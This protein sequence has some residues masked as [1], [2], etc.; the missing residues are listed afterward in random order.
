MNNH[1]KIDFH[2]QMKMLLLR[3]SY[4]V[5]DKSYFRRIASFKLYYSVLIQQ[6]TNWRCFPYLSKK[7]GHISLCRLL[8][9]LPQVLSASCNA[10]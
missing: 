7:T 6:T 8:K 4:W 3:K 2:P 10:L 5:A 1:V 9:I